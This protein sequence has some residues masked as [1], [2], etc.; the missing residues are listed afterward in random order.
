MTLI[1]FFSWRVSLTGNKIP[2]S[3][4]KLK[5]RQHHIFVARAPFAL[6]DQLRSPDR[7]Q[8]PLLMP[9]LIDL[10]PYGKV[11]RW[12][13]K[14]FIRHLLFTVCR[15][16]VSSLPSVSVRREYLFEELKTPL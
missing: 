14:A 2:D 15:V 4:Q 6:V 12:E 3:K 8:C 16:Q 5:L 7:L 9:K 13:K 1:V 10:Q 11:R